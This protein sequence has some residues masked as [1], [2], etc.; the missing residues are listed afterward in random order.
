MQVHKKRQ[1]TDAENISRKRATVETYQP[2][3]E[4]ENHYRPP[5]ALRIATERVAKDLCLR[6]FCNDRP[7]RYIVANSRSL[8][9]DV[10]VHRARIATRGRKIGKS[11]KGWIMPGVT[12]VRIRRFRRMVLG[13]GGWP[14]AYL[15]KWENRTNVW[16]KGGGG[17]TRDE[18]EEKG[19]MIETLA[20]YPLGAI[21]THLEFHTCRGFKDES[22]NRI[23]N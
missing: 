19:E 18:K 5:S 20:D 1:V 8:P 2:R 16:E 11:N 21:D 9:R 7:C 6:A 3:H 17:Q 15:S 23:R 10:T 13:R 12:E 14:I 4:S 22:Y